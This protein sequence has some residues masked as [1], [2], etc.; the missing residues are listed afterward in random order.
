[1]KNALLKSARYLRYFFKS[2]FL[3]F[4]I[5][6][7]KK[8]AKLAKIRAFNLFNEEKTALTSFDLFFYFSLPLKAL[9]HKGT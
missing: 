5:T 9:I 2:L 4:G 7:F 3:I 1:V 8:D 6:G